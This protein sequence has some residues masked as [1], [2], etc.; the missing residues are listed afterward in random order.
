MLFDWDENKAE[1]NI[2]KHG[3]SFQEAAT[4]FGDP[5]AWTY[6]DPDHSDGERRWVTLG[7]SE[8]ERLLVVAHV[9]IDEI[10]RIISAREATRRERH[11]YEE[12]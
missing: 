4:V 7:H 1:N 10:V 5:L 8:Q 6:P 11:F 3:V 9:G 2:K 12:G